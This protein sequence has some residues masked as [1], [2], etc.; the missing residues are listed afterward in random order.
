MKY[1]CSDVKH[2]NIGQWKTEIGLLNFLPLRKNLK[3]QENF[4]KADLELYR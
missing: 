1:S 3:M 2:A 4:L